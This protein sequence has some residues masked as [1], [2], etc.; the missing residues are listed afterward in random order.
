[1]AAIIESNTPRLIYV[2]CE[3]QTLARDLHRLIGGG[4]Q[5]DDLQPFD[6]F[7]H[8]EEVETVV[9]LTKPAKSTRPSIPAL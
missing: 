4:Y 8:T 7:P 3:P 1:M 2:S 6:M 9:R 5:I